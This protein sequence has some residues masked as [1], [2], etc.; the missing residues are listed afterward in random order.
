MHGPENEM[1]PGEVAGK[2]Q[3]PAPTVWPIVLALGITLCIA[4]LL[5]SVVVS[6]LGL[7]LSVIASVGW[8]RNV[9]PHETHEDV[10]VWLPGAQAETAPAVP[11]SRSGG[12]RHPPRARPRRARAAAARRSAPPAST[13][14]KAGQTRSSAGAGPWTCC[15]R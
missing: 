1:K 3:L 7:L 4:G 9:L 2:L 13:P 11:R 12:A 5:T 10:A 8:F 15:R 14:T 6:M